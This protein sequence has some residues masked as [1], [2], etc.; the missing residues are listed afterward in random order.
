VISHQDY[1]FDLPEHLIA[2]EPL[3]QAES[4]RLLHVSRKASFHHARTMDLPALLPEK[5]LIVAND[6]RVIPA[7]LRGRRKTGG[8]LELLPVRRHRNNIWQTLLKGSLKEGEVFEFHGVEAVFLKREQDLTAWVDFGEADLEKLIRQHG[9]LPLPPYLK[10]A[11][12]SED[13]RWYQTSYARCEGAVAAPTAG[14]HFSENLRKR[15]KEKGHEFVTVTLHVGPG[16]FLPVRSE[17]PLKHRV[18][19]ERAEV[20]ELVWNQILQH[21][22]KARPLVALGTTATRVLETLARRLPKGA[23][24]GEVSLTVTPPFRFKIVDHLLTNFHLPDSSLFLLVAAFVGRQKALR[25]YHEAI[26]KQYRFYSYG[27]LCFFE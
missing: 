5:S 6:T 21:K 9:E 2:R 7:R 26:R 10:R 20:S 13:D 14:F 1:H 24:R 12:R 3:P 4:S 11:P 17:D 16:T 23:F 8:R 25:V 22:K 18:L 15:L 27:D 19:P